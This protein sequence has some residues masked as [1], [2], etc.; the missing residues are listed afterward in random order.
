VTHV[1]VA[2]FP[3]AEAMNQAAGSAARLGHPADDALTPFPVPEVLEQLSHRRKRPVGWVMVLGGAAAAGIIWFV[4]W[5]SAAVDYPIISGSRPFNSWQIFFLVAFEACIL[6]GGIA[7]FTAFARDCSLP[8]LYHP[9]F[10][11]TAIERATQTHFFLVFHAA[12]NHR[13]RVSDLVATLNPIS[14]NEIAL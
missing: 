7:G 14:V 11:I 10:S 12:E 1:F 13:D 8:S 6:F 2:E 4:Q 9:L 5:Y 3:S